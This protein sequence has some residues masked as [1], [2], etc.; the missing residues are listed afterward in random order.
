MSNRMLRITRFFALLLLC[1]TRLAAQ[2]AHSGTIVGVLEELPA[3]D[4][5]RSAKVRVVQIAFEKHEN[6]WVAIS[7]ESGQDVPKEITW[8]IA[9][10]GRNLGKITANTDNNASV[11]SPGKLQTIVSTT[12]VP[13]VGE[14]SRDFSGQLEVEVLRPL[15]AVSAPNFSDPERWKPATFS[16]AVVSSFRTAFRRHF[17]KLCRTAPSDPSKLKPFSYSDEQLKVVKSYASQSGWKLSRMHLDGA[18]D[19]NDTDAGFEIDDPWFVMDTN[20]SVLYLDSG[21]FLVDAG[22]YDG[23]GKSELIFSIDRDN[24]GGYRIFYD[25]FRKRAQLEYSYH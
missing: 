8:T 20:G 23:D 10:D 7:S 22:D 3:E 2:Q 14:R 4:S 1:M 5:E 18:I 6:D 24:R 12:P 25:E 16:P 17:G 19:C 11:Y 13:T 15:V 21:M 9:F